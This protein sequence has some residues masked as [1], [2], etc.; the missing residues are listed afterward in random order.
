MKLFRI[1]CMF[2]SYMTPVLLLTLLCNGSVSGWISFE[3]DVILSE[4]Q[5]AALKEFKQ[6]VLPLLH[7]EYMKDDIYLAKWLKAKK[8]H[9]DDAIQMLKN[10][11]EWRKST[12]FDN[13]GPNEFSDLEADYPIDVVGHDTRGRPLVQLPVAEWDLRLAA[14][15]GKTDRLILYMSKTFNDAWLKVRELQNVGKNVTRFQTIVTVG[16]ISVAQQVNPSSFPFYLG[17]GLTYER[18][19]P[20]MGDDIYLVDTAPIFQ[21]VINLVKAV[22]AKDVGDS[23]HAFGRDRK[24]WVEQLKG[25]IALDQLTHYFGGTMVSKQ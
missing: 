2:R 1:N 14:I 3:D 18:N 16:K 10:H 25:R 9:V 11:L 15:S 20:K 4:K 7:V 5:G 23:I 6:R 17:V 24:A 13:L 22:V 19:F 12:N 8:F 21:V